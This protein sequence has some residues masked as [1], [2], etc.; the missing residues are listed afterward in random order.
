MVQYGTISWYGLRGDCKNCYRRRPGEVRQHPTVQQTQN[1]EIPARMY[2]STYGDMPASRYTLIGK[3]DR[4]F[5]P[6]QGIELGTEV[7]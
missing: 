3:P 6:F 4:L 2:H 1:H 5:R 7:W